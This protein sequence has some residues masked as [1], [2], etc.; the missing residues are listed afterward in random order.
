LRLIVKRGC[1]VRFWPILCTTDPTF[2]HNVHATRGPLVPPST[3]QRAPS[4]H[5]TPLRRRL[6]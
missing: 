4:S 1:L 6:H 5:S 2:S 3:L